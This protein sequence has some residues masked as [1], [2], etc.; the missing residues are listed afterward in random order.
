MSVLAKAAIEKNYGFKSVRL[1]MTYDDKAD[2][3]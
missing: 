3:L 2:A 1:F